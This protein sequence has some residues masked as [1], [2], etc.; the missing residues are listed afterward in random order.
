GGGYGKVDPTDDHRT[1]RDRGEQC[2]FPRAEGLP[3]HRRRDGGERGGHRPA[4]RE[5]RRIDG[6]VERPRGDP[7]H[8]RPHGRGD[9]RRGR[10]IRRGA[11]TDG[12]VTMLVEYRGSAVRVQYTATQGGAPV[13]PATVTVAF[14]PSGGDWTAPAAMTK[15]GTGSYHYDYLPPSAGY[16]SV[17]V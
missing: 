11:R 13:D 3:P 16:Y 9:E 1:R 10:G 5:A 6:G 14:R 4:G 7:R 17:L 15:D 12:E 2:P 8:L